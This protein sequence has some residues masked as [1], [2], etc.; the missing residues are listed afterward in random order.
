MLAIFKR[1]DA[2][3]NGTIDEGELAALCEAVGMTA[4][5]ADADAFMN[6]GV[7]EPLEFFAFYVKCTREEAERAFAE[8]K[9]IFASVAPPT[10][11]IK[12]WTADEVRGHIC[13]YA[14]ASS[15]A[16]LSHRLHLPRVMMGALVTGARRAGHLQAV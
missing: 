15:L 13:A 16:R 4:T 7:I 9:D 10:K 12:E 8:H 6:D 5:M 11:S 2:D 1:F 14:R 3:G